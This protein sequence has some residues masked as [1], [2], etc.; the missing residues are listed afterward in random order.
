MTLHRL[1]QYAWNKHG[2]NCMPKRRILLVCSGHL[3]GVGMETIL[4][5]E[6]D[7]ELIGP[8]VFGEDICQRISKAS[9]DVVL[10]VDEDSQSEASAELTSAIMEAYPELPIIRAGLTENLVRVHSTHILPARG[11][12]LIETIRNLP[13]QNSSNERSA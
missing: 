1:F 13:Y 6:A 9:P 10:I 5:A 7:V 12:D 2:N 3:F 8:W 11:A 4:R